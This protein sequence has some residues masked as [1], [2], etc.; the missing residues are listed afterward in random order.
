M[1]R[2]PD[3]LRKRITAG[4]ERAELEGILSELSLNT[5]CCEAQCPNCVECFAAKTAT[6]MILGTNCTRNCSF[7]NVTC[8]A[9]EAIDPAEPERV[10]EAV[11]RLGLK[12]VVVT[13]VT[14]DDLPDGG[15]MHFADTVRAI[16][17]RSP[18]T[19]VEVL[20]PDFQGEKDALALVTEAWPTVISHNME[21]VE[22]LYDEV[23]PQADYRRSLA[24]LG[25]IKGLNPT[26]R[27]KSGFMLGLGET[28][29]EVIELMGDLR[30]A[31]CE[32]L[33]IGQYLAPSKGHHPVREYVHPDIFDEYKNI[34]DAKGFSFVASAPFVRSSYHAGEA[35]GL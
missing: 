28:K 20:I 22:A 1:Q 18:M 9:P 15:A 31:G 34:A 6:F 17:E 19:A 14:R 32:L 5:V 7:C 12:Y 11:R 25:R 30:E 24:L 3:W 16:R 33:T 21:T 26:I 13:S 35:L 27:S 23:R 10:A 2:K 8:G 4:P 29:E